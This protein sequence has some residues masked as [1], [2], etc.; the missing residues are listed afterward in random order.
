MDKDVCMCHISPVCKYMCVFVILLILENFLIIIS[1]RFECFHQ[2]RT[3]QFLTLEAC[4][5]DAT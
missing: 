1:L 4:V 3:S 2:I 5:K